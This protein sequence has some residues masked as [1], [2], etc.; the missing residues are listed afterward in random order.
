MAN[1]YA[2]ANFTVG[3]DFVWIGSLRDSASATVTTYPAG[4]QATPLTVAQG[5]PAPML[6]YL[7]DGPA[8]P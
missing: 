8:G 5:L 1:R 3:S 6:G 2:V 4:F 7:A